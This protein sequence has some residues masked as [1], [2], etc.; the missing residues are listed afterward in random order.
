V[1]ADQ[2]GL[3]GSRQRVSGKGLLDPSEWCF[4]PSNTDA[5]EC[6]MSDRASLDMVRVIR[7]VSDTPVGPGTHLHGILREALTEILDAEIA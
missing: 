2:S 6:D 5:M 3:S 7:G 1:P 4:T